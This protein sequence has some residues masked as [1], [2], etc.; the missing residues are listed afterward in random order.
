MPR[1]Q[2]TPDD[3]PTDF[4]RNAARSIRSA[5][6]LRVGDV[7]FALDARARDVFLEL[8]ALL[9]EEE[10][11]EVRAVAETMTTGEAAAIL[12][13][14]RP[15]LVKLLEAGEIPY[16]QPGTHRRVSRADVERFLK[17]REERR[18]QA[19]ADFAETEHDGDT[20]EFLSTR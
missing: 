3:V 17:A 14:S 9:R 13:I 2:L 7:E 12:Q 11:V 20:D 6:V 16:D 4:A 5:D 19:L 18:S 1:L 8:F 15:T 10:T